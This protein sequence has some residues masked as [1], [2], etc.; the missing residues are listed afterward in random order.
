ME[1][2]HRTAERRGARERGNTLV[3]CFLA[4]TVMAAFASAH[5]IVI[6]KN[7][8]QSNFMNEIGEMRRLADGGLNLALHE[9]NF[10]VGSGDGNIGTEAWTTAN[11]LGRDGVPSTG[12]EGEMD[13]IPTPGEPN[14]PGVP[15]GLAAKGMR[16]LV[17]SFDTSWPSVK[18]I[19]STS[20][21]STSMAVVEVYA[22]EAGG[23]VPGVG[24][25]YVEPGVVLDLNGNAFLID[26]HDTNPDGSAGPEAA[27]PGLA[28]ETGSPA[29][30]NAS[31]LADQVPSGRE[32]QIIGQ[33]GIPSIGESGAVDFD[34][35]FNAFKASA[36]N[37]VIPGTYSNVVWGDY[38]T[39][40]NRVTY[41]NGDLHLSGDGSGSGVLIVEGSLTMSGKFTFVGLVI[42]KGDVRLTGGGSGVHIFGSA[43]I[44]QS[45]TA[46]DVDPELG[47]SGNADIKYSSVGLAM[48]SGLMG[49]TYSVLYWN[50]IK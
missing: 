37:I 16:L 17:R 26:G 50:D 15:V 28:T 47:V 32:D 41:C 33:G 45:L 24:A 7:V 46:I 6:Q 39:S 49:T 10:D 35:I 18:R 38:A 8:R 31:D 40:D 27:L 19:V 1:V 13:G 29:G 12:D 11:D 4:V 43:M 30:S 2:V 22:R 5:M 3:V 25:V 48:A 9:L 36:T 20:Y 44:G 23:G 21:N 34:T 42:V 14:C